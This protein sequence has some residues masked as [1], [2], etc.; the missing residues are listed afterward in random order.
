MK[1]THVRRHYSFPGNMRMRT[2]VLSVS[3][4]IFFLVALKQIKNGMVPAVSENFHI[5][6][7]R[8]HTRIHKFKCLKRVTMV[9]WLMAHIILSYTLQTLSSFQYPSS[10]Q[11]YLFFKQAEMIFSARPV[12]MLTAAT[13]ETLNFTATWHEFCSYRKGDRSFST[14]LS[15]IVTCGKQLQ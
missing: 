12:L 10:H 3:T 15:I 5:F 6:F 11:H 7:G 9:I 8:K 14:S 13:L 4:Q 2:F 1:T